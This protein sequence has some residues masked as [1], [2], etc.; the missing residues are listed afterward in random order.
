MH[1]TG[2]YWV[3]KVK[4]GYTVFETGLTHSESICTFAR[5]ADGLS[6]AIAY[7]NYKGT[8]SC[9]ECGSFIA[10][11]PYMQNYCEPC[12]SLGTDKIRS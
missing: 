6:L 7:C 5:T 10:R 2:G 8:V 1:E 9:L 4:A 11:R 12:R 3:G